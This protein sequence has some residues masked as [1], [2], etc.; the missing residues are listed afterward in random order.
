[1]RNGFDEACGGGVVPQDSRSSR[2]VPRS[3]LSLTVVPDHAGR[4]QLLPR[5]QPPRVLEQMVEHVE[6]LGAERDQLFA[7]PQLLIGGIE[8]KRCEDELAIVHGVS[9]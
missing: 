4:A 1:M 8:P 2:M 9:R 6:E 3:T 5:D 7:S